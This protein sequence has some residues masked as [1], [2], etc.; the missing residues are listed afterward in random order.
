[1]N[2]W[3]IFIGVEVLGGQG[4]HLQWCCFPSPCENGIKQ[5]LWINVPVIGPDLLAST[6]H[7]NSKASMSS[8]LNC[9]WSA[10]FSHPA[11][12]FLS[13]LNFHNLSSTLG[14]SHGFPS[15]A[16]G[17]EPTYQCRRHKI[18]WRRKRQPTPIFLSGVSHVQRSLVAYR[19]EGRKESDTTETN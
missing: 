7:R 1:M 5:D 2:I 14:L 17:K 16:S 10:P 4:S 8:L 6:P 15:G 13:S 19:S 12:A 9:L 18:P 3:L 11:P